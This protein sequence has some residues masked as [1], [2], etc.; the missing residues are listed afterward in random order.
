MLLDYLCRIKSPEHRDLAWLLASPSLLRPSALVPAIS[1]QEWHDMFMYAKDWIQHDSQSPARLKKW[2]DTPRQYKLG[3]YAEDLFL[4]YLHHCSPYTV[5]AHDIQA[6]DG[7]R[8]IGAF[9]F[10]VQTPK[11]VIEHWE[12]AIKYFVQVQPSHSWIDFIGPGGK[13]SLQRKMDK[14]LKRQILL[15]DHPKAQEGL[16]Q[17][18]IPIPTRKRIISIGRLFAHGNTKFVPPYSGDPLQ[19]TGIW[20]KLKEFGFYLQQHQD[21][22]WVYRKHPK[23]LSPICLL[24]ENKGMDI[25]AVSAFLQQQEKHVMLSQV[26]LQKHGWVETKRLF[27]MPD[28]WKRQA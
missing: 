11:G 10:I 24:E 20:L 15:S 28:N 25:H 7:K 16:Q 19:P 12:M 13:D 4:Y 1:S 27:V 22:K 23:W 6:F 2:I 17:R 5:L 14:M 21:A 8:S 18:N 26:E 3:L 9:D